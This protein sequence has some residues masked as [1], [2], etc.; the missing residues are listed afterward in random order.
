MHAVMQP[1]TILGSIVSS[2]FDAN[3]ADFWLQK[4]NP[5][6]SVNDSLGRIVEKSE[7]ASDTV[8][9][10][11]RI[12]KNFKMGQ[13]GQHHPVIVTHDGRRYERT[14]SLTQLDESHVLLTVK[15]IQNG[16]VSTWL[17]EISKIGDVIEFGVPYGDMLIQS[18]TAPLLL[19]AAGSGIT[20][21]YSLL[22][23]LVQ[24]KQIEQKPVQLMYW[25]KT[26]HDVAFKT[27]LEQWA[28]Q[29][30]NFKLHVFYTQEE[31]MDDRLNTAHQQLVENLAE[32]TVYSCGP[33]GF[34][35]TA[36]HV[37]AQAKEVKSEAFSLTPIVNDETGFITVTLSK[38]NQNVLIPKG[39]SILLALEQQNIMPKH[40]CRMGVCNK[41]ACHKAQG[42]TKNLVNGAENTEPGNLLKICVNSAQ[43]DLVIDL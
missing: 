20:P 37:F 18:N 2:V 29:Y 15:K 21:M 33:S 7:T 24:S 27:E 9:L 25:V 36:E 32:M 40:G 28:T 4:L 8:S 42:S 16:I 14:Y 26:Q 23:T 6:W 1:K 19:L 43:T 30:P 35:A 17:C 13:A 3:A 41:C 11:I 5:I 38:S 31:A 10:K 39:Q 22:K 34:V 12:N